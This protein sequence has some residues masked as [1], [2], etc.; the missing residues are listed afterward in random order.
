MFLSH[1]AI[2]ST[3]V[4]LQQRKRGL[5]MS[6][7]GLGEVKAE[8]VLRIGEFE[9]GSRALM[10]KKD[11]VGQVHLNTYKLVLEFCN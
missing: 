2:C 10:W 8:V 5:H 7:D 1:L 6:S 4:V 9:Q 11:I 3:R